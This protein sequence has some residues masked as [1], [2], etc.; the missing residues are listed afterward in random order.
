MRVIPRNV[1]LT[2][3][4]SKSQYTRVCCLHRPE[5]QCELRDITISRSCRTE[6]VFGS[7]YLFDV[8]C[9]F[10]LAP[11]I[12][13][14]TAS[15]RPDTIPTPRCDRWPLLS[16]LLLRRPLPPNIPPPPRIPPLP[17][18]PRWSERLSL[19]WQ[20]CQLRLIPM[21]CCST[22]FC[23]TLTFIRPPPPPL[24]STSSVLFNPTS[25]LLFEAD[26]AQGC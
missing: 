19:T 2:S 15:L 5:M 12:P 26:M 10:V 3:K 20:R 1:S 22:N 24:L 16:P 21:Q 23:K 8:A 13:P 7:I 25:R 18:F 14:R 17:R 9:A 11:E 6:V 4:L